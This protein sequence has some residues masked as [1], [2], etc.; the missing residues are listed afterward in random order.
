VAAP[1]AEVWQAVATAEGWTGWAVP[2]AWWEGDLLETSYTPTAARG[3]TTTI[4]QRIAA[5]IP[6]RLLA[7][8]TVKAPQGFPNFDTFRQVTHI[9]EVESAGES[10]T[11]VRLTS[12]GYPDT[13]AGRQ[14][15]GFF[16]EGNRVTL[17]QLR[18]RFIT[19]PRDWTRTGRTASTQGE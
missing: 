19:G 3:D 1:V 7:F 2:V 13:E 15:L 10:R 11:R 5:A 14:L 4:Q 17:D 9:I 6:G 12:G 18:Q 16:R 8:R